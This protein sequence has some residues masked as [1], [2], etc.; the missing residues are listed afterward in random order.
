MHKH[1][2][3][4]TRFIRHTMVYSLILQMVMYFSIN[5]VKVRQVWLRTKLKQLT[6]CSG[7]SM[8]QHSIDCILSKFSYGNWFMLVWYFGAKLKFHCMTAFCRYWTCVINLDPCFFSG[9]QTHR[10]V[11]IF[12][13][14]KSCNLPTDI[15]I[16]NTMIECCKWLPCF[17]SASALLSLMLR[18][19]FNPT[20]V[21]F[22]SLLKVSLAKNNTCLLDL[23]YYR[24]H[25]SQVD[26]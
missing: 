1:L 8:L 14:M 5:L 9:L 18:D 6:I 11:M 3:H 19:G 26:F 25:I 2:Q 17:K 10:A 4:Q 22:T 13:I 24:L 12:K 15:S 7:G 20:V 21:T 23:S 16:Y